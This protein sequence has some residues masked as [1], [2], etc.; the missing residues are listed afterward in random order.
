[1]NEGQ[2]P[3]GE[4]DTAQDLQ[5]LETMDT[6]RKAPES[7]SNPC[8]SPPLKESILVPQDLFDFTVTDLMCQSQDSELDAAFL[9]LESPI[10]LVADEIQRDDGS[11]KVGTIVAATLCDIS[12]INPSPSTDGSES[13]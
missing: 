9:P 10:S 12:L 2:D 8:L 1:M 4:I 7:C 5:D 3:N 11:K 13:A 6:I